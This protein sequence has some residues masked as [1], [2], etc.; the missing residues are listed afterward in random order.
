[1]GERIRKT[2]A[3][4][5]F[6]GRGGERQAHM[7]VSIGIA[8]FPDHCRDAEGLV[9]CADKALYLAKRMGKNRV[10]TYS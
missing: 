4:A 10:E 8:S 3:T 2:I 7:T 1:V 9:D 5:R 6:E